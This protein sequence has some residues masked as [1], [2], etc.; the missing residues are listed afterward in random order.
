[1]YVQKTEANIL[2]T[3]RDCK[4]RTSSKSAMHYQEGNEFEVEVVAQLMVAATVGV[5]VTVGAEE[6]VEFDKGALNS[7]TT[8]VMSSR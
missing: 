5:L 1:M 7:T 4:H 2:C 8:K 3:L 6:G